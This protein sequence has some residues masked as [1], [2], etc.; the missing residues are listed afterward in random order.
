MKSVSIKFT[1]PALAGERYLVQEQ[2][3]S[4]IVKGKFGVDAD[5]QNNWFNNG[6][7]T[8]EDNEERFR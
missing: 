2:I 7:L 5:V 1:I 6:V 3:T 8:A 4:P